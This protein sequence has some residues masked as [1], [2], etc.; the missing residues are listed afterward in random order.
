M[1]E[2]GDLKKTLGFSL[3]AEYTTFKTSKTYTEHKRNG[4]T[5]AYV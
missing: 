1:H 5:V 4:K 2:I 3:T